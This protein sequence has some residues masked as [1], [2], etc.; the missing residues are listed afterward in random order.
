M[1][2]KTGSTWR[3]QFNRYAPLGA[4]IVGLVLIL[5]TLAGDAPID[6]Y[7]RI[8]VGTMLVLAGG[9]Y[10]QRPFLTSERTN[11]ALRAEVENFIG[12]VR[13]LNRTAVA[14]GG[15]PEF[16]EVTSEMRESLVR[17]E[18]LAGKEDS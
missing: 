15:G 11:T 6:T 5:S 17:I 8:I 4:V 13:E 3:R 14:I 2:G 12:L 16:E 10:A 7:V 18:A 9:V 1:A